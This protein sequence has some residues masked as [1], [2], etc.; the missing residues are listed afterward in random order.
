MGDYI[1]DHVGVRFESNGA[2]LR[3]NK[4]SDGQYVL[5]SSTNV[6]EADVFHLEPHNANHLSQTVTSGYKYLLYT[7]LVDGTKLYCSP[8]PLDLNVYEYEEEH[9]QHSVIYL[10]ETSVSS[11]ITFC[12][13]HLIPN[14]VLAGEARQDINLGIHTGTSH[15]LLFHNVAKG[16][17]GVTVGITANGVQTTTPSE[18]AE[19]NISLV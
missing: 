2:Y 17:T 4:N 1:Q 18:I 10:R 5:G 8:F 13:F 15:R 16:L 12:S 6:A 19:W 7:I 9:F 11:R 3:V 14:G